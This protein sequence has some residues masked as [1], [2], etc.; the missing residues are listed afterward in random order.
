[1]TAAYDYLESFLDRFFDRLEQ[2][3]FENLN[4]IEKTFICVWS[5][6]G[7][8]DNGGFDQWLFNSSGNWALETIL[9]LHRIGAE[10]TAKMVE[11]VISLF[12]GGP[13]PKDIDKRR[14]IME[15]IPEKTSAIWNE[16][17]DQFYKNNDDIEG[18]LSKYIKENFT[19]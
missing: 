8:V 10:A 6:Q 4:E 12:P 15:S 1:M 14:E 19:I 18:L 2:V 3:G 16:I 7:E 5:L 13:P 11:K 17:D 9:G